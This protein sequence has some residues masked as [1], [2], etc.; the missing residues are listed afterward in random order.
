MDPQGI[1]PFLARSWRTPTFESDLR[2][3]GDVLGDP[4]TILAGMPQRLWLR[5]DAEGVTLLRSQFGDAVLVIPASR[6][7][8]LATEH[9]QPRHP[10]RTLNALD[11]W[12]LAFTWGIGRTVWPR[13]VVKVQRDDRSTGELHLPAT[14]TLGVTRWATVFRPRH[15]PTLKRAEW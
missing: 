5:I 14:D 3:L 10:E 2:E 1:E 13:I 9:R 15:W 8:H 11:Q 7:V 12:A 6:I 4:E